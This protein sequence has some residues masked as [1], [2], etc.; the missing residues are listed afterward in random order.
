LYIWSGLYM[1]WMIAIVMATTTII[2]G[3]LGYEAWED[4]VTEPTGWHIANEEMRQLL[5]EQAKQS[6]KK[7]VPTEAGKK[8]VDESGKSID[9]SKPSKPSITD[10]GTAEGSQQEKS[11]PDPTGSTKPSVPVS[12]GGSADKP[13]TPTSVLEKNKIQ[14]NKATAAQLSTIPGIGD[15]KAKAILAHRKQIGR[16]ERIEQLLDVKGIGEK[17]LEKMKPYLIIE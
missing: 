11:D 3:W 6:E 12:S 13:P 5:Q 2:G 10:P 4:D 15:S 8:S 7:P 17:V 14:L 16:F 1:K 9:K